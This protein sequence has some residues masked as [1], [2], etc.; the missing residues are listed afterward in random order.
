M[1]QGKR[2][3]CEKLGRLAAEPLF[4][5]LEQDLPPTTSLQ[6]LP[7]V[8]FWSMVFQDIIALNLA[9]VTDPSLRA[10]VQT[11]YDEDV[12]H[13]LWL[14]EDLRLVYGGLPDVLAIFDREYLQ[15][16]TVSYALMSEVFQAQSDWER[17]ILPIVLEE[18]GK[19]FLPALIANFERA[20]LADHL[21][22]LG[23]GH[24][25]TE[26]EHQLHTD[27]VATSL[28]AIPL[29]AEVRAR[30]QAMTDRVYAVFVRFAEILDGVI[31]N[32]SAERGAAIGRRLRELA[33]APDAA[34]ARS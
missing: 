18:A 2:Y 29:P 1:I 7:Y 19:I 23:H 32:G 24:V 34:G 11:H 6:L 21:Q 13:N 14:A 5:T 25:Q 31:T 20:G 3:A 4:R 8:T 28:E 9:R 15:A 17:V 27:D 12:G 30:G 16:R 10:I 22:A 33:L 26:A